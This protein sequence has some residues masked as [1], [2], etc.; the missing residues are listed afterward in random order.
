MKIIIILQRDSKVVIKTRRFLE[1]KHLGWYECIDCWGCLVISLVNM[2]VSARFNLG[3]M[4]KRLFT[5]SLR[6][7]VSDTIEVDRS[8]GVHQLHSGGFEKKTQVP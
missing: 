1:K 3:E 4:T 8:M 7:N 5:V 2:Y 6:R